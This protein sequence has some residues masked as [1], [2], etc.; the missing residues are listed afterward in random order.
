MLHRYR[1]LDY[2]I[3]GVIY[4]ANTKYDGLITTIASQLGVDTTILELELKHVVSV[5]S[6][7]TK[8]HNDIRLRI[9]TDVFFLF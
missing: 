9:N 5:P 1:Y 6:P 7:S 2:N 8:I 4:D 3:E